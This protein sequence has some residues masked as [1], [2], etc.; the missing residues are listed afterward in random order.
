[1]SRIR[2]VIVALTVL[3]ACRYQPARFS[4]APV[5]ERAD[6]ERPVPSP[7]KRSFL[8][9]LRDADIYVRRELVNILDPKRTTAAI[10]VNALDDVVRSSWFSPPPVW[11]K[12]LTGYKRLGPPVAPFSATDEPPS[13]ETPGARTIVDARGVR[14]ELLP[15]LPGR[16]GM[17]TGAAATASRLVYALGY[18]TP[19][20]HVVTTPE[21]ERVA[22]TQWPIGQDLGPTAIKETRSDDPNDRLEQ[23]DRRSLR[24]FK[25]I[26]AWLDLKRLPP[27]L[28]RDAYVG[29]APDGYVRHYVVGLDGALGVARYIDAVRWVKDVDRED[30]NF[31]LR[32]FSLGLSPKPAAFMPKTEWPS[33]GLFETYAA[34]AEYSPSPPFEPIDRVTPAD[35]YWAAKRL[36]ALSQRILGRAVISSHIG[37]PEQN[38]LLQL[39]LARRAQVVAWGYDRT[40]PLEVQAVVDAPKPDAA[41]AVVEATPAGDVGA[42]ELVDLAIKSGMAKARHTAYAVRYLDRDGRELERRDGLRPEKAALVV[43]LPSVAAALDY[44]VVRVRGFRGGKALPG[45]VEIHLRRGAA[46][47]R[48]VGVRH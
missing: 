12:P 33:A 24:A 27:R 32:L 48:V 23:R 16:E 46:G 43:G 40:T 30:S 5:V 31:F 14:Y 29:V 39:L 3:S 13:S 45:A 44:V 10:D 2:A 7:R 36:A 9:P 42:L 18:H 6:D 15:D 21:G 28:F 22:A 25:L 37:P 20:V 38:W 35:A 17:R 41:D 19:E 4:D 26:G 34:P 8:S 1:M 11:E 47:L